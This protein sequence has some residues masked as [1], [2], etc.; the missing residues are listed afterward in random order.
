MATTLRLIF[1]ALGVLVIVISLTAT[2]PSAGL[3][4]PI[5]GILLG[6]GLI[7][8]PGTA[9][10]VLLGYLLIVGIPLGLALLFAKIAYEAFGDGFMP[11]VGLIAG[12]VTGYRVIV[13]DAFLE[14]TG[15]LG[16]QLD[17]D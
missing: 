1:T 8:I 5:W 2:G 6:L 17:P 15:K 9:L 3:D 14:F 16:K 4:G 7:F 12:G 11:I 10:V 13:S